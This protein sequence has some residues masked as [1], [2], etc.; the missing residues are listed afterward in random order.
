MLAISQEINR[1]FTP[2]FSSKMPGPVTPMRFAPKELSAISQ[3]IS[4][5][6]SPEF[7]NSFLGF[8]DLSKPL[9]VAVPLPIAEPVPAPIVER[10]P[11][12]GLVKNLPSVTGF[13]SKR[14][15]ELV[16][17]LELAPEELLA[18]S[19]EISLAFSPV[20]SSMMPE[21]SAHIRLA[22]RELIDISQQI[23]REFS[24]SAA[25]GSP[26]LILL[27][28]DPGHLHAY[29]H[30]DEHNA[31]AEVSNNF[32]DQLT[33][34]IFTQANV[35]MESA[36]P[37]S[38][39]DVPVDGFQSQQTVTLPRSFSETVY[40]AAIGQ[41]HADNSFTAFAYSNSTTR[42][43]GSSDAYGYQENLPVSKAQ[44][45]SVSRNTSGQGKY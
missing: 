38:W 28:V 42:P 14:H 15:P 44:V 39:F 37:N 41:C 19:Q 32:E 25:I 11:G 36:E 13:A 45:L 31:G 40:S 6:F 1:E 30:L 5:E 7:A 26:E 3:E 21:A 4:R 34:R 22:E 27:P 24:A 9:P 8:D 33:L 10:L 29:W 20:F 23:T 35:R 17:P 16:P 43:R 12:S 2:S 18:I